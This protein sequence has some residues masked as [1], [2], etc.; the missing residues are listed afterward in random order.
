[1]TARFGPD[2]KVAPRILV[3]RTTGDRLVEARDELGRRIA[4]LKVGYPLER[5]PP[6]GI[7]VEVQG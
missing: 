6:E 3:T 1:M 2:A 4:E 7:L 5:M